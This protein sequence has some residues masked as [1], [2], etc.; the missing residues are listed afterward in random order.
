[1]PASNATEDIIGGTYRV[2]SLIGEGGMGTVFAVEHI[3][4]QKQFAL[5]MLSKG[6]FTPT[7]WQRFQNEAQSMAHL[8]HNNIIQVTDLG[9]HNNQY[10]YYVM[11]LLQGKSLGQKIKARGRLSLKDALNIFRQ[12]AEALAFVHEH[13]IIHRDIK[14]DNIMLESY[15]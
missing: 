11:E 12:V 6:N 15:K 10:P 1:M 14:P 4:L 3:V 8:K 9:I 2:I 13:G 5:K 7:D